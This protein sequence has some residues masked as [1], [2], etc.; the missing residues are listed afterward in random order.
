[1]RRK[2]AIKCIPLREEFSTNAGQTAVIDKQ[3]A[4][5]DNQKT[6]VIEK[7]EKKPAKGKMVDEAGEH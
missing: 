1:M 3:E 4:E 2:V 6:S 7:E 5:D